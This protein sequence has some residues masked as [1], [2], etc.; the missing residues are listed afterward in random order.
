LVFP[1]T[2]TDIETALKRFIKARKVVVLADACHAGGIGQS[3]DIAR[4]ANRGLKVNPISSGLTNLS[5]VSDGVA[6]FS[7][8]ADNQYSQE[9][10]DW[11]GGHGVFTYFLLKGLKGNADFNKDGRVNLGELNLYL[12]EQIRRTTKNAQTPIVSG[13]F[14]P[15]LTIG[16]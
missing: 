14:D 16:K 3:F 4:R 5:N 1:A 13:K 15:G 6:I 2:K 8:S 11:G 7:A 10:K 9:S 12:S